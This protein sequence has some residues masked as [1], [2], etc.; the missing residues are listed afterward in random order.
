MK[1][2][3]CRQRKKKKSK[4]KTQTMH[5]EKHEISIQADTQGL[6]T[7]PGQ[8]GPPVMKIKKK[9]VPICIIRES[10]VCRNPKVV[11]CNMTSSGCTS[12]SGAHIDGIKK[13][14]VKEAVIMKRK[15]AHHPRSR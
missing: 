6:P 11:K 10:M 2:K 5:E 1:T 8:A 12:L 3:V 14:V 4:N 7:T 15:T 13:R 9:K